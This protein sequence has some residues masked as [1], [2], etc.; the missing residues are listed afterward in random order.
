MGSP[1]ALPLYP[2]DRERHWFEPPLRSVRFPR[3]ATPGGAHPF[4]G[5]PPRHRHCDVGVVDCPRSASATWTITSS[6]AP[7]S[8]PASATSRWPPRPCGSSS[9][10]RMSFCAMSHSSARCSAAENGAARAAHDRSRWPLRGPEPVAGGGVDAPRATAAPRRERSPAASTV[11][12]HAIRERCGAASVA[13]RPA[14]RNSTPGGCLRSGISRHPA[15]VHGRRAR[16]SDESSLAETLAPADEYPAHPALFDAALQVL[17][18]AAAAAARRRFGLV[19]SGWHREVSYGQRA[20]GEAWSYAR[21]T[22]GTRGTSPAT[23]T[24]SATM[25]TV[26]MSVNGLRCQIVE[27]ATAA[28]AESIDDWLYEDRW[29]PCRLPGGAAARRARASM[30]RNWSRQPTRSARHSGWGGS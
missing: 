15:P 12:L 29:E 6:R 11:D 23:C 8:F 26:L 20:A 2:W 5:R 3:V 13:R 22:A 17:I 27:R 19:P 1:V 7:S 24:S 4:L 16:R 10:E 25:A 14:T 28:A 9:L 30:C 21:V 18:G